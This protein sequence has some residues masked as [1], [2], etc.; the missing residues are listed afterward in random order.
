MRATSLEEAWSGLRRVGRQGVDKAKR[1]GC[2]VDPL[3]D[4]EYTDLASLKAQALGG[5]APAPELPSALRDTF[6]SE[7]VQLTGVRFEGLPVAAVLSVRAGGYGMLIDGA[8][9]REHWDKNPNNLAV[10]HAVS[11]LVIAGCDR[12][13]YGF[14]PV[15]AGDARF[16]D[17]MGGR[18]TELFRVL[19]A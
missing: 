14:S 17:H 5:R 6:G 13:D 15:G 9:N 7:S 10:W 1:M 8:S 19:G 4:A 18:A 11:S 12:V 16:K 3:T 2:R